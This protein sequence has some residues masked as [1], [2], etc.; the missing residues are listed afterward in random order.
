MAAIKITRLQILA[1][2]N[3]KLLDPVFFLDQRVELRSKDLFHGFFESQ[4]GCPGN[5]AGLGLGF[6]YGRQ[7]GGHFSDPLHSISQAI[8]NLSP[9]NL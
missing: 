2:A 7:S 5:E 4:G 1:R 8:L 9:G 3:N 6:S